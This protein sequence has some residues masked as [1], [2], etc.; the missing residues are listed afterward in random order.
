MCKLGMSDGICPSRRLVATEDS[1]VCF[2]LL[3]NVF[4][5]S[6]CLWMVGGGE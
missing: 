4:G 3:V 5:F 2:S 1:E 6:I